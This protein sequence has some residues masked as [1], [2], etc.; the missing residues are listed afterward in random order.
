MVERRD[1][2]S[3]PKTGTELVHQTGAF[4]GA[5]LLPANALN[6]LQHSLLRAFMASRK[7]QRGEQNG[8]IANESTAAGQPMGR[9]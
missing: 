7:Q 6:S 3:T 2:G 4:T 5:N 1:A 8:S 9:E